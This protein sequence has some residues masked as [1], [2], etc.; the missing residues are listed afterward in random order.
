MRSTRTEKGRSATTQFR[1]DIHARERRETLFDRVSVLVLLA[2]CL[3]VTGVVNRDVSL[4]E[5]R[6][7]LSALERPGPFGQVFGG[8]EPSILPGQV[9]PS[10]FL[11]QILGEAW[12]GWSG[13]VLWPGSVALI[14]LTVM[15]AR[16]SQKL[17]GP[18]SGL[19][20]ILFLSGSSL[21]MELPGGMMAH[22]IT[23]FFTV[24]SLA[25]ALTR[26]SNW[27][28]GVLAA[29]AVFSGGWPALALIV[30]P[31]MIM[32][33]Q[34]AY[35]S[36]P[37]LVPPISAFAAWSVWA[38][39][40]APSVV[41]AQAIAAPLRQSPGWAAFPW[42]LLMLLPGL[43]LAVA[44]LS[45]SL[46]ASW[47]PAA[48]SWTIAWAQ[49][50]LVASLLGVF[51]PGM[52]PVAWFLLAASVAVTATG[53][54]RSFLT[55]SRVGPRMTRL[56]FGVAI[57]ANLL[58]AAL[59]LPRLVFVAASMGYYQELAV[60]SGLL[61]AFA[62]AFA[63]VGAW[64]GRRRWC[65]ASFVGL[66]FAIKVAHAGIYV[67][68][69]EYRIGQGPWAHAVGQWV[70]P[71]FPIYTVHTWPADFAFDLCRP[72]K[73]L[74]AAQWLGLVDTPH[75]RHVLLLKAEFD[76]WPADAP[77]I[78]KIREFEDE[79]GGVRVLAKTTGQPVPWNPAPEAPARADASPSPIPAP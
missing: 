71:R 8:W 37:L 40:V 26:G 50:G 70:P 13:L 76:H 67:P 7:G 66:T 3:Q 11:Y 39:K 33:R 73:Q 51:V 56:I 29:I 77:A 60:I 45:G 19:L 79:R 57:M 1:V 74:V 27:T 72:V 16:Q 46:R 31:I 12:S 54:T 59:A 63:L 15:L 42:V 78:E 47:T 68:E 24:A 69:R 17:F 38:L 6:I 48:R 32:G 62:V 35:L 34:G 36:L 2:G 55:S 44:A 10:S 9:L 65:V 20:T 75:P 23:G 61:T 58:W 52:A 53:V 18:G 41:W 30:V 14:A 5:A 49:V 4:D 21:F 28:S 43:G 64:E 25:W 22:A